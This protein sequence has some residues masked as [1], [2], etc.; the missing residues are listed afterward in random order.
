MKDTLVF[1]GTEDNINYNL[2]LQVTRVYWSLKLTFSNG[3][4]AAGVRGICA[5]CGGNRR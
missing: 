1:L 5:G 2:V 3:A 4:G